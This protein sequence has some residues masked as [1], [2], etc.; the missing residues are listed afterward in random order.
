M[1]R[2]FGAGIGGVVVVVMVLAGF[3]I[4][5]DFRQQQSPFDF[6]ANQPTTFMD[7]TDYYPDEIL[8]QS[9]EDT[10]AMCKTMLDLTIEMDR[11]V[12]KDITY[13]EE[14]LEHVEEKS[15]R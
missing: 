3:F 11:F 6:W 15:N 2:S 4:V 14:Y 10:I 8:G 9:N 1:T 12:D 13:C 7:T 5:A